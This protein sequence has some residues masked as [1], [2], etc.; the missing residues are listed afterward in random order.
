MA[1]VSATAAVAAARLTF[2]Q[3]ESLKICRSTNFML[4]GNVDQS[5]LRLSNFERVGRD[6]FCCGCFIHTAPNLGGVFLPGKGVALFP[7]FLSLSC[8]YIR[9]HTRYVSTSECII[10]IYRLLL[11]EIN[12]LPALQPAKLVHHFRIEKQDP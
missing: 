1:V 7:T 10:L 6:M 4:Y 11:P 2:S 5:I 8:A 12:W 3:F 9:T